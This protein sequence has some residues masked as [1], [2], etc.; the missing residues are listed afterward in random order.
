MRKGRSIS[1]TMRGYVARE[2]PRWTRNYFDYGCGIWNG[3][4]FD[5]LTPHEMKPKEIAELLEYEHG[6]IPPRLVKIEF[7]PDFPSP[8][9]GV[10]S[11]GRSKATQVLM[12][13]LQKDEQH[14]HRM[15]LFKLG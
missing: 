8:P 13:R 9:A 12:S 2:N 7:P 15:R 11:F 4:R 10:V 6:G 1:I 3:V 5:C 14:R